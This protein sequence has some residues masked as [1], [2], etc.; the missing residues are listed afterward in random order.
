[1]RISLIGP[2]YPYRGGIAH[3]TSALAEA[4]EA[5]GHKLQVISFKRQYPAILYPGETDKDTSSSAA[6]IEARYLLDPF[7]P[8]TW[9]AA[10]HAISDHRPQ[11]ALIQWWTTFWGPADAAL[12]HRL[13]PDMTV[14]YLIHNVLP[15][16]RKFW[17]PWIA[18]LALAQGQ[19]FIVQS[20]SEEKR[21][22]ALVPDAR[23]SMCPHPVYARLGTRSISREQARESLELPI[24]HP[25]VLFFGIVRSYKGLKYLIE[26]L[27]LSQTKVPVHLVVAGEFWEDIAAYR[28][29][30]HELGLDDRV[31]LIDRY[32]P[33]EEAH[34]LFSAVDA[35]VAPYVGGT[36]SGTVQL[37][38][39]YG[40]PAIVSDKIAAGLPE[41]HAALTRIVPAG[42]S[43]ALAAALVDVAN[44]QTGGPP[45]Q[46]VPAD[47]GQMVRAVEA[48]GS[49]PRMPGVGAR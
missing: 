10:A 41:D 28:R 4:L 23:I 12:A 27:A 22:R 9:T 18:H 19:R 5:R 39:G 26:A 24:D 7:Y 47:W 46:P 45:R 49:E 21:L 1:M 17:D 30:I 20:P 44:R 32:V 11:V 16:E 25:V 31:T 33:N 15:H 48:I 34:V 2:V 29:Q 13:R 42:D 40:L 37:A 38:F 3:Y 36:Q 8:W 43:T 35:L 14:A 6:R